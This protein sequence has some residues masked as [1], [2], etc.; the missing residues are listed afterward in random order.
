MNNFKYKLDS[1]IN[2]ENLDIK[3]EDGEFEIKLIGSNNIYDMS[4][5]FENCIS[6]KSLND[7]SKLNIS[8]IENMSYMFYGCSSLELLPD[9]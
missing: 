9:I 7:F 4:Y 2:E 5:M 6:L 8:K 1:I 3:S